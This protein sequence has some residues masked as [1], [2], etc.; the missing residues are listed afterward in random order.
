MLKKTWL[1]TLCAP[2]FAWAQKNSVISGTITDS[3]SAAVPFAAV[4]LQQ[5][6]RATIT[7]SLGEF[8]FSGLS[9][10][11]YII[12]INS[13]GYQQKR[14]T[15]VL[16]ENL[17]YYGV[18]TQSS[19]ELDEVVVNALRVD[20]RMGMAYSN[21]SKE[22]ISKQNLGQD[23]PYILNTLPNVV[24]NSDAGNGVGYTGLRVRGSD[25]T[26]VNVTI[27]GVPINDAESQGTFWVNMPDVITSADNVQLQRGVGTSANGAGAFGASLN[28]QTNALKEKAYAQLI[29][30]AGSFGTFRN[31]IL[32]GSGLIQKKFSLDARISAINSNGYIDRASSNLN[33]YYLS[34]GYYQKKSVLKLIAF[35][36]FE[37]TYQAWN[38]VPEDSIKAGNR[39]Y[40]SCGQYI[41]ANGNVRYYD[42]ET[43]NYQQHNFQLHFIHTFNARLNLSATA[44]YTKGKGYYEQYRQGESLSQYGLAPLITSANDTINASD[45]IRRLWLNNDFSGLI[46]TLNY[47]AAQRLNFTWGAAYN[48]YFGKHFG[49]IVRAVTASPSSDINGKYGIN[50]GNKND[51]NLYLKTNYRI[52]SKLYAFVDLQVRYVNYSFLGFNDSLASQMQSVGYL[53]FNPKLGLSYDIN[54]NLAAYASLSRANKEPNRNDFVQSSTSSRP[55]PEQLNDLET[56]LRYKR[57]TWMGTLNFYN[58]HYNN[59][60]VL[61]GAINDVGA[62]NRVNVAASFRRGVELELEKQINKYFIVGGNIS[63]SKNKILDFVEFIDAFDSLNNY[64]QIK[65]SYAKTDISFSPDVVAA[66]VLSIRPIK[67]LEIA[68]TEKYVGRQYLDNT[69]NI[70][71]SIAPYHVLDA[72]ANYSIKTKFIPEINFM[73]SVYNVLNAQYNTN[74]YTFGYYNNGSLSTFNFLAPAA[75]INFLGGVSLRF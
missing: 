28:F 24:V 55:L 11:R 43:D 26:R 20:D 41:D 56:G 13:V 31:S 5:T 4:S 69:S 63:Y 72:R 54:S 17:K 6:Q 12:L 45:L 32:F 2:A 75:P 49:E 15:L 35:S 73:L 36:G 39:T 23:A 74:G 60:L 21:L 18:L 34:A 67:N 59:Q 47:K 46:F 44:H 16:Q 14:D 37:K 33:G 48:T 65:N 50:T 42:N 62:Y 27:N 70:G 9:P 51:G 3:N 38:Y 7:N 66:V 1:L 57:K 29:S 30:T 61:N 22:A 58:M 8:S 53:F 52:S 10:G 68:F 71:R 64:T 25:G 19:N 40:N